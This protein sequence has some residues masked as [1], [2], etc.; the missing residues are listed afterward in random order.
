MA[1]MNHE[2]QPKAADADI[3]ID[4]VLERHR[5]LYPLIDARGNYRL[6]RITTRVPPDTALDTPA[7]RDW[8]GY[9]PSARRMIWTAPARGI[10]ADWIER[11]IAPGYAALTDARARLDALADADLLDWPDAEDGLPL[12]KVY[13][14]ADEERLR[15]KHERANPPAL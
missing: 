5:K 11:E 4:A 3:D 7:A 14:A 10:Y 1:N 9:E 12:L 15:R 13:F 2:P 8:R 6:A